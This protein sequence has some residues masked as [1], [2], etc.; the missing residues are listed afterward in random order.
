MTNEQAEAVYGTLGAECG[1]KAAL[2]KDLQARGGWVQQ[3]NRESR[4]IVNSKGTAREMIT[5]FVTNSLSDVETWSRVIR[6][7]SKVTSLGTQR[8]SCGSGTLEDN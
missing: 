8:K 7:L 3:L 1:E 6:K 5:G 4:Q 2:R